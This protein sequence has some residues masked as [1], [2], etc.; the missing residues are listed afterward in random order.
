MTFF[1]KLREGFINI[2][3]F[4]LDLKSKLGFEA[5]SLNENGLCRILLCRI[6]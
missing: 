1:I 6:D 2:N 4:E 3:N 5:H